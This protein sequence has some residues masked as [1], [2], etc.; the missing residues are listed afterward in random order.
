MDFSAI[1]LVGTGCVVIGAVCIGSLGFVGIRWD[2]LVFVGIGFVGF[3][4]FA[5]IRR[6]WI[7]S[8]SLGRVGIGWVVSG[9]G[10]SR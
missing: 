9:L 7:R 2:S 10:S 1:G 8:D 4:G 5:K 3:V 6:G